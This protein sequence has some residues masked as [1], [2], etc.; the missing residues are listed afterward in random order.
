[1]DADGG[2]QVDD[3]LA[4]ELYGKDFGMDEKTGTLNSTVCCACR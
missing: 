4:F 3:R 2:Y 1:M